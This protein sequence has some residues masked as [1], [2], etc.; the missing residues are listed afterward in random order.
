LQVALSEQWQ[1]LLRVA[2]M[3]AG[4]ALSAAVLLELQVVLR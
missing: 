4:V 1:V 3:A 2:A